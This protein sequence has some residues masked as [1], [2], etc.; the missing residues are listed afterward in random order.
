MVIVVLFFATATVALFARAAVAHRVEL[1]KGAVLLMLLMLAVS[2]RCLTEQMRQCLVGVGQVVLQ[3][4]LAHVDGVVG[5]RGRNNQ[6]AGQI[7]HATEAVA[8]GV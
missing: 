6:M 3:V 8:V 2:R 4:G 7:L 5:S 1:L